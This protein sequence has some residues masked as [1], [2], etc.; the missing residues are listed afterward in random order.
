[1]AAPQHVTATRQALGGVGVWTNAVQREPASAQRELV[2]RIEALG[3]G[4]V[5]QGEVVG[6]NDVFAQEAVWLAATE[7]IVAGTG[8]AN[9]WARHPGTARAAAA[10]LADA[11][12]GRFVLG[13][14]VSHA[15]AV[16]KS[17][18]Q[19][20]HPLQRMR[21]YLDGL[22]E[23][24]AN[25]PVVLAAL[26]PKMLQLAADRADG[27]HTYFVPPEHTAQARGVLGPD[28]LLIP[29]QAVIVETS[30]QVARAVARRH[31]IYYLQL[32]NYV[33]NLRLLGLDD[34]DLAGAGSDRLVDAIVAWG[35][36]ADIA[37]RIRAHRDA[38]ADHVLVH[39]LGDSPGDIA[40]QL[41]EL[42]PVL[43]P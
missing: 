22:G 36:P 33:N 28:R 39:P 11:W 19:Y 41:E 10:T 18:Q 26:R 17:G 4:S 2:A 14:G 23:R 8:I 21:D 3:Y 1:M 43:L 42:A 38:G 7:R 34:S 15:P 37:E 20:S 29:E 16:E 30:P 31:T 24:P 6:T 25:L 9:I 40:R 12:P 5:W 35:T 13:L 32:P 27:V